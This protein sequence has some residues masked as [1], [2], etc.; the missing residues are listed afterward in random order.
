MIAVLGSANRL[1]AVL[2]GGKCRIL[3]GAK[4]FLRALAGEADKENGR[5]FKSYFSFCFHPPL[6]KTLETPF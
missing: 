4:R 1:G 2:A 3:T 5:F 6:M